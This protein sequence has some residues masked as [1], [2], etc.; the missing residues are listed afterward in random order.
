MAAR[1]GRVEG[2][3]APQ[4]LDVVPGRRPAGLGEVQRP[5]GAEAVPGQ[6]RVINSRVP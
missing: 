2:E 5:G 1:D 4:P 6:A 3:F